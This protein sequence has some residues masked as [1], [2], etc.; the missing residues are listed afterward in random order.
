VQVRPGRTVAVDVLAN[1]SDPDGD[2]IAIRENGL[3]VPEGVTGVIDR[4]RATISAP[5]TP[6]DYPVQYTIVDQYGATAVGQ[7]LVSVSPDAP[8]QAPIARDDLVLVA[9]VVGRTTTDVDVTKNDDDPDGTIDALDVSVTSGTATV[10]GNGELRIPLTPESQIITYTVT[11]VDDQ[12]ASAFVFVPGL[13]GAHP[14]L[15]A[16]TKPIVVNSGETISVPLSE[17]VVTGNGEA[18]RITQADKV[19]VSHG[20]GSNLVTD[21]TTLSYT[22]ADGYYGPDALSFEVTDGTGPDD[23]E[24]KKSVLVIPITVVSTTNVSPTMNNGAVSVEPG[25]DE[26]ELNLRTLS[27]DPDEGDL[28]RLTYSVVGSPAQG[29]DARVEGQTLTVKAAGNA[30]KGDSPIQI[31]VTD[32]QS[33]PGTGTIT[34]TVVT[35]TRPLPSATDDV[36]DQA[37][38]GETR[39]VDVLANDFNPYPENPLSIIETVVETGDGQASAG[40]SGVNV[41]PAADFVGTMVVRYRIADSTGDPSRQADGRILL[42]VQGKP[43]APATPSVTSIQDRTVVLSWTPPVNNGSPITT[44]TVSSPQGYTKQ[45]A[46]TTCT[47]DGLTNDVEYT[48]TVTATNGV[49]ESDPSPSSAVARPDARPDRPSPPTL[50]FGDKSL[51]VSWVTPSTPGSAVTSYNLEISPAPARGA[52][53]KTGVTG[54]SVVWEGLENGVSYQVRVQAMNRA[55]DPSDW[56]GFSGAM[57]PAGVPDAP[58]APTSVRVDSVGSQAQMNVSWNAPNSNGD[59]ISS[60][61]LYINGGAG[62]REIPVGSGVTSQTVTVQVSED[63]YTFAVAAINK[64]GQGATSPASAPRRSVTPPNAPN[65]DNATAGD[66]TITIAYTPGA[67][68]GARSTEV[69]YQYN[70]GGGWVPVPGDMVIRSGVNNN[71]TYSVSVRA[72]TVADGSTYTSGASNSIGGLQPAGAPNAP[73]LTVS[74][75]ENKVNYSW[76]APARNGRDFTV[77]IKIGGGEWESMAS[78]SGDGS[79]AVAPGDKRTIHART[80]DSSQAISQ[81]VSAEAKANNPPPTVSLSKGGATPTGDPKCVGNECRYLNV[82]IDGS[83]GVDYTISYRSNREEPEKVWATDSVTADGNGNAF[84]GNRFWGWGGEDVWVTV[85]GNDGTSGTS[86]HINPW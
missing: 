50:V 67:S 47:L 11:D 39:S 3:E 21:A 84:Q 18:A 23:P 8:L 69:T 14:A 26:K 74:G 83:A 13:E 32:G 1:D 22:S 81:E 73:G 55:P 36:V 40:G 31:E 10:R 51:A 12:K 76:T 25:G 45:C 33:K 28:K 66:N 82:S 77:Q 19:A 71:G 6:G 56:S 59:T 54:N 24:G 52:I 34:V 78:S 4:G 85:T 16:G 44:Y 64:A 37:K 29:I 86:N 72:V 27:R 79:T 43:D 63:D 38:Q 68:N 30:A 49:G 15:K 48:F 57:V 42:T 41:T 53:Q 5:K 70:V 46:S 61:I 2:P 58:G 75:G 60:Y 80:V 62:A 17:Y 35:S 9:D 7:L 65:L 20:N